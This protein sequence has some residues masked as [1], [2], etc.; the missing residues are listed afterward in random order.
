MK[1][2][3]PEKG[4]W[5]FLLYILALSLISEGSDGLKGMG[6]SAQT[7]VTR[8]RTTPCTVVQNAPAQD[9]RLQEGYVHVGSSVGKVWYEADDGAL[10]DASY[11]YWF[12]MG[13]HE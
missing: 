13:G 10:I 7:Y 1:F 3:K 12:Y 11:P 9:I 5:L 2:H 8:R 6:D 4:D